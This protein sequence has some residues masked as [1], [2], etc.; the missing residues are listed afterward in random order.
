MHLRTIQN[1]RSPFFFRLLHLRRPSVMKRLITFRPEH[2]QE[3]VSDVRGS[4]DSIPRSSGHIPV[5]ISRRS[6][7]RT[8]P[9][10]TCGK[11]RRVISLESTLEPSRTLF[12]TFVAF[13]F[14]SLDKLFRLRV[15]IPVH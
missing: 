13:V 10:G 1:N 12:P 5:E 11:S 6:A 4:L 8:R 2:S 15:S 14:A 3:K 9:R 7:S